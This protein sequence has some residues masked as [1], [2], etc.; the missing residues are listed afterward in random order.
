MKC[1]SVNG[2]LLRISGHEFK[3]KFLSNK[4]ILE[5]FQ[6]QSEQILSQ[7]GMVKIMRNESHNRVKKLL[8]CLDIRRENTD[9]K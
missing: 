5:A 8:N 2:E 7:S 1:I 9:G 4:K 3:K 6:E